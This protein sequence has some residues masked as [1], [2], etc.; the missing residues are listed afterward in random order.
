MRLNTLKSSQYARSYRLKS[1]DGDALL[2]ERLREMGFFPGVNLHLRG[3]LPLAGAW[4]VEVG[5]ASFA[6]RHDEAHALV[7]EAA[8]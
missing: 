5:T 7:L 2:A 1:I 6:I 3:R 8:E 4:L